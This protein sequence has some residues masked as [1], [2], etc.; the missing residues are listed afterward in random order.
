MNSWAE[1]EQA[2]RDYHTG[3]FGPIPPLARIHD[4]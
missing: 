3:T 4:R 2:F 1:I